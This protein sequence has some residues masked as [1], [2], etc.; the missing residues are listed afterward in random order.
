MCNLTENNIVTAISKYFKSLSI[1]R[2]SVKKRPNPYLSLFF[3]P[4]ILTEKCSE[5]LNIFGMKLLWTSMLEAD[6]MPF[7]VDKVSVQD[8]FIICFKATT[9]YSVQWVYFWILHNN[10]PIG[11][12]PQEN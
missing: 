3:K 6:L 11:K 12:P 5:V 7:G 10:F 9:D 4:L 2:I 8:V 1:G